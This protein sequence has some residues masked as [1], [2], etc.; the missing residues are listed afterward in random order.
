MRDD[1]QKQ[2]DFHDFADENEDNLNNMLA[3]RLDA[4]DENMKWQNFD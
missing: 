2:Q 3:E 4:V 1:G